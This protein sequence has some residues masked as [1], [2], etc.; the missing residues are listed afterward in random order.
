M[1]V[2]LQNFRR[3]GEGVASLLT[4]RRTLVHCVVWLTRRLPPAWCGGVG[5]ES[6]GGGV[7]KK[8]RGV[9]FLGGVGPH[10][11]PLCHPLRIGTP[12]CS[13][14]HYGSCV[15]ERKYCVRTTPIVGPFLEWVR[16][17]EKGVPEGSTSEVFRKEEWIERRNRIRLV[18]IQ[19]SNRIRLDRNVEGKP[20]H[21]T[22]QEFYGEIRQQTPNLRTCENRRA[23]WWFFRHC[24]LKS[25]PFHHTKTIVLVW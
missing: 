20:D 23:F 24:S 3:V 19:V 16:L 17:L 12:R 8:V 25:L 22:P 1:T 13:A 11:Q 7:L 6:F 2:L 14:F 10:T 9:A 15:I 4:N 5:L 21:T 18:R